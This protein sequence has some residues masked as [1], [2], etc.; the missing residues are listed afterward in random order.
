M[1]NRHFKF[2]LL[3]LVAAALLS[4]CGR[5]VDVGTVEDQAVGSDQVI[6]LTMINPENADHGGGGMSHLRGGGGQ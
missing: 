3:G 2:W 1:R 6:D 4:A 5:P